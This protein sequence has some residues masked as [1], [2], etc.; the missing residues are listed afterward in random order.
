MT[1][2]GQVSQASG[3]QNGLGNDLVLKAPGS[4]SRVWKNLIV[5]GWLMEGLGPPASDPAQI[6]LGHQ[7]RWRTLNPKP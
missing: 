6:C 7:L 1:K 2:S 5:L 4:Q 3:L